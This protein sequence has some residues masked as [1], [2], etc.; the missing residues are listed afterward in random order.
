MYEIKFRP[1]V[2]LNWQMRNTIKTTSA[3]LVYGHVDIL[4]TYQQVKIKKADFMMILA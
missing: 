2:S 3:I 4:W 1:Y